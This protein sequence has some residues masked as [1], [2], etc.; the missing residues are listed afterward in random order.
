MFLPDFKAHGPKG[1]SGPKPGGDH[2]DQAIS[3]QSL[4][5]SKIGWP[6][7]PIGPSYF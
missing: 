3:A 7:Q 5:A 2:S 1:F 4:W 6:D